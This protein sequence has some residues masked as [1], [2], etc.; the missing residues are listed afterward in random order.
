MALSL[1]GVAIIAAMWRW[2]TFHLYVLPEH[3]IT[4]FTSIT[5]NASYVIGAIVV[6]MVTGR[7]IYDW[8]NSTTASVIQQAIH[9]KREE[10]IT[11][12]ELNA[13]SDLPKGRV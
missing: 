4:A 1:I 9:E 12:E 6:F 13:D 3:S 2:A 11:T 8:K 10:H 7:L 5:N